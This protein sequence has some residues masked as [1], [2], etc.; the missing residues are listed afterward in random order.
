MTADVIK[1]EDVTA[2]YGPAPNGLQVLNRVSFSAEAGEII[3]IVGPSGCGKTTLL[4]LVAGLLSKSAND[5]LYTGEV[6]VAASGNPRPSVVYLAQNPCLLPWRS[7]A[8]NISLPFE[9]AGRPVDGREVEKLSSLVGVSEFM[10]ALPHQLSGGMLQ[11]VALARSLVLSP[12]ALLLDEP[13]AHLDEVT[14]TQLNREVRTILTSRRITAV[15]V[16]HSVSEAVFLATSKV[17][18]F[19]SRPASVV[20]SV[21]VPKQVDVRDIDITAPEYVVAIRNARDALGVRLVGSPTPPIEPGGRT[22]D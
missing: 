1:V 20:A 5:F 19:S 10:G 12:A 6:R 2:R 14:S 17:L 11:R 22:N 21:T 7:V 18:V 4:K 13:F 15:I 8:E 9:L 16:S 3:T